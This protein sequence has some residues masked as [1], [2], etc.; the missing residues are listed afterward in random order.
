MQPEAC[1]RTLCCYGFLG[2]DMD[3]LGTL[4]C[5][6]GT[7][8]GWRA[9]AGCQAMLDYRSRHFGERR[10]GPEWSTL[11]EGHVARPGGYSEKAAK[12]RAKDA[13]NAEGDA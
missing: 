9:L 1:R 4:R 6:K 10:P 12:K 13:E 3:C 2:F 8:L 5:D 11:E 7:R